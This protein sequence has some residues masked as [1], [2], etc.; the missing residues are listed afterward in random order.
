MK[1]AG[2]GFV[3]LGTSEVRVSPV[4]VGTNSWG[5]KGEADPGK[6]AT[7]EELHASGLT[8]LDT[9]EIYT[10]GSSERTIGQRIKATGYSPVVLT[11]F[12]PLPWRLNRGA[13]SAALHESLERLQLPVWTCTSFISHC[14]R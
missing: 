2:G 9:A 10:G 7:F 5:A 3:A 8:F 4:G 12:F 6:K 1:E 14:R 13:L 11:K